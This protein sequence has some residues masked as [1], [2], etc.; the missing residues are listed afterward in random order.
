MRAVEKLGRHVCR[1]KFCNGPVLAKK[2]CAAHY[3]RKIKNGTLQSHIPIKRRVFGQTIIK[4]PEYRAWRSMKQRC[5]NPENKFFYRY[6]GRGIKVCKRWHKSENFLA[7]M[8]KKPA[9]NLSLERINNNKG[10]SPANCKWA[11]QKEQIANRNK[12]KRKSLRE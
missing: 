1:V 3:R 11:T 10:Y 5:Y 7:D 2:L 9:P 12:F 6:G 8:G 4:T